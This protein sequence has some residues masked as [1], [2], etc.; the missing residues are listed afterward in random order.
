MGLS[1]QTAA[2]TA[3]HAFG[4]KWR[5]HVQKRP[6]TKP[7]IDFMRNLLSAQG[8]S[9]RV[10]VTDKRS[11][12]GT[13]NRAIGL[14]VKD[15]GQTIKFYGLPRIPVAKGPPETQKYSP[16]RLLRNEC[17]NPLTGQQFFAL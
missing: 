7:S 8:R 2:V 14:S 16:V 10:M 5:L 13:A 6:D 4:D 9:L 1:V 3:H 17:Q 12:Y 11:S 15:P